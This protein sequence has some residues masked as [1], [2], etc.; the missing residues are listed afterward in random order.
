[1]MYR[2]CI[3]VILGV[4]LIGGVVGCSRDENKLKSQDSLMPDSL[5]P[6]SD[7]SDARIFTYD[8]ELLTTAVNAKRIRQYEALDSTM[9]YTVMIEMYDAEGAVV[10]TLVGD[11]GLIRE[12]AGDLHMYGHVVAVTENESRL[13]TDSLYFD[14]ET[15]LIHTD[16]FVR[17]TRPNGDTLTGW[18]FEADRQLTR[19]TILRQVSGS[20]QSGKETKE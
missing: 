2:L 3:A 14:P 15:Q 1:M 10:S 11:S 20:F 6:D 16:E 8:R 12:K 13:E 5:R 7:M 9:G 4:L 17:I 19:V 18:G